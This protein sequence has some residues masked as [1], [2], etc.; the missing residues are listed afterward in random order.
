MTASCV[1]LFSESCSARKLATTLGSMTSCLLRAPWSTSA[2]KPELLLRG[3]TPIN[4]DFIMFTS[5]RAVWR[6]R[7]RPGVEARTNFLAVYQHGTNRFEIAIKN[8]P[9]LS[10][11]IRDAEFPAAER[12]MSPQCGRLP[13]HPLK[14][15]CR[16]GALG[17]ASV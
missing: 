16:A 17:R 13:P 14:R 10:A 11:F 9:R 8:H 7:S 1:I 12:K 3:L 6:G 2:A 15:P 5:E 4:A